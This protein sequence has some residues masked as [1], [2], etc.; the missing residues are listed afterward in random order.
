[1]CLDISY[2]VCRQYYVALLTSAGL[3]WDCMVKTFQGFGVICPWLCTVHGILFKQIPNIHVKEYMLP[4]YVNK[5]KIHGRWQLCF[6]RLSNT[7]HETRLCTEMLKKYRIS[8]VLWSSGRLLKYH[9]GT[10]WL[11]DG[12]NANGL[13]FMESAP[14]TSRSSLM[15]LHSITAKWL[16][17]FTDDLICLQMAFPPA[18]LTK[19]KELGQWDSHFGNLGKPLVANMEE[20]GGGTCS[21]FTT[22]PSLLCHL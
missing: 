2:N 13:I 15:E 11:R 20:S 1:M 21:F 7:C 4:I 10:N 12:N 3:C 6:Q 18:C 9:W 19:R 16:D 14:K 22:V 5:T 8:F 17:A